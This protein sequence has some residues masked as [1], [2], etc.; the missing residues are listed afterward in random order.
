MF[1]QN[2]HRYTYAHIVQLHCTKSRHFRSEL[3]VHCFG[4][5]FFCCC[6]FAVVIVVVLFY[7]FFN[8]TAIQ[9]HLINA[10]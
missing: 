2:T 10:F 4:L 9:L 8:Y 1:R 6:H 5:L 7:L 3:D